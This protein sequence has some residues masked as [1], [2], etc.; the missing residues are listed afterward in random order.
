MSD[1]I[2]NILIHG[3]VLLTA[4]PIHECAHALTA[5]WLGDD[6]AKNQGRMTLNP[7]KHLDLFGTIF[8]LVGGFGWAKAVPINPN[9]FKNRKVGMALSSL[10]GPVSNLLLAYISM[11]LYK[12]FAYSGIGFR[13]LAIIFYCSVLLNVGLAVFNL[14]P[15]PPLDGSRIFNL[16]LP[17]K[18]YFK[19]MRYE[20]IIFGILFFMI[21]LGFLDAPLDFLREKTFNIMNVITGWVDILMI[22]IMGY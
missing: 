17:E 19:I 11:I 3:L 10:A 6:T 8:M 18:L 13:E 9:N 20:N 1:R 21:F 22:F 5:H 16:V 14:L 15:I 7:L 12:V 2:W 4:F